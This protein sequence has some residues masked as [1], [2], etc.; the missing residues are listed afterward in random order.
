MM[1]NEEEEKKYLQIALERFERNYPLEHPKKGGGE[2]KNG[3]DPFLIF[4]TRAYVKKGFADT[5]LQKAF[6]FTRSRNSYII[7]PELKPDNRAA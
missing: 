3:R 5:E 1:G 4:Y 6:F 7:I 2:R